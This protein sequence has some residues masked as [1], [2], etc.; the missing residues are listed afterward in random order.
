MIAD[1]ISSPS[2]YGVCFAYNKMCVKATAGSTSYYPSNDYANY[3]NFG[4]YLYEAADFS[5]YNP[6]A[7][8]YSSSYTNIC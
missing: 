7:Y 2:T 5:I 6:Q 3:P 4:S 1:Y 8:F